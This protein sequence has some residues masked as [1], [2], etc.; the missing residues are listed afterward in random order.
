MSKL[1]FLIFIV[2]VSAWDYFLFVQLWPGSWLYQEKSSYKFTNNYFNVHGIW[3]QYNNGT[4]P[5]FCNS[6][7]N[8][9]N[10]T[11]LDP[12]HANLT[13]YWTDF[14]D[15]PDFWKHEFMKHMV[16]TEDTFSD[17]YKFFWYG[18]ALREKLDLF[19]LLSS[20]NIYPSNEHYYNI[21]KI[22]DLIKNKFGTNVV[23]T[24]EKINIITEIHFCM[25]KQL[26]LFDCPQNEYS[27]GC[28]SDN[29]LYN[30]IN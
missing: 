21:N 20:N 25:N 9:F 17:P 10:V 16:C 18:L 2:T 11:V 24:C 14:K 1:V 23:I 27:E 4:W 30:I 12:I 22:S 26:E 8:H 6:T 19:S 7:E 28:K 15:A 29:V 3:P 5:Q 13:K